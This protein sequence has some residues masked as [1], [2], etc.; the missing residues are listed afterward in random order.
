MSKLLNAKV[1]DDLIT[2]NQPI[3]K[4]EKTSDYGT[5]TAYKCGHIVFIRILEFTV[6]S[7]PEWHKLDLAEGF[8]KPLFTSGTSAELCGTSQEMTHSAIICEMG[9]SGNL[10][11]LNWG[12]N[13]YTN[14]NLKC[15][16]TYISAE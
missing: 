15:T 4:I 13:K 14:I 1:G 11:I 7:L 2:F 16:L 10:Y 5:I 8:P 3:E 12:A 6:T 9:S